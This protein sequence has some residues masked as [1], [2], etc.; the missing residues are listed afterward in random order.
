[1]AATEYNLGELKNGSSTIHTTSTPDEGIGY[2]ES[3][4]NITLT[5]IDEGDMYRL[6]K[7]QELNVRDVFHMHQRRAHTADR[8]SV[9]FALSP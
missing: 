6:G 3:K 1:M 7:T 9:I 8:G 5:Q 4:P 2:G